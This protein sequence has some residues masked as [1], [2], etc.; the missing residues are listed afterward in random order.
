MKW[1]CHKLW[2]GEENKIQ[3]NKLKAPKKLES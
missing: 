3:I 1:R 2:N